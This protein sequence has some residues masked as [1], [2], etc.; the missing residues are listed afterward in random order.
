MPGGVAGEV[1][2]GGE[3]GLVIWWALVAA[4]VSH[5]DAVSFSIGGWRC[6]RCRTRRGCWS[7]C[8]RERCGGGTTKARRGPPLREG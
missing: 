6:R 5:I 8:S 7:I 4:G 2:G 3:G 1:A